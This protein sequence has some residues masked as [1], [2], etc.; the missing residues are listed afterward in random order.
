MAGL[1]VGSSFLSAA[2]REM[3]R[4]LQHDPTSCGTTAVLL[5]I[6]SLS[7]G[8]SAEQVPLCSSCQASVYGLQHMQG[9]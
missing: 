3:E 9:N 5:E 7:E 2:K 1:E 4:A 8:P 6:I